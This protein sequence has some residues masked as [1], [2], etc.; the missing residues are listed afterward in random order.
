RQGTAGKTL[1]SARR[2]PSPTRLVAAPARSGLTVAFCDSWD[3]S[4][5]LCRPIT[6]SFFHAIV[7]LS[8]RL[9]AALFAPQEYAP[10]A[11]L[12]PAGVAGRAESAQ[13]LGAIGPVAA[14]RGHVAPPGS[15][16]PADAGPDGPAP[17]A[18]ERSSGGAAGDRAVGGSGT[19]ER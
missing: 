11:G 10:S 13:R 4:S 17:G 5:S 15:G 16:A 14:G 3:V 1:R 7:F 12:A 8:P 6:R 19:A 9:L 18:P 2:G